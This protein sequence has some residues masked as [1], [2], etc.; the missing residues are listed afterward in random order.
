MKLITHVSRSVS[1]ITV[2]P[3]TANTASWRNAEF[4]VYEVG[5]AMKYSRELFNSFY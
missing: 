2:L 3:P 4:Q 5:I 1:H